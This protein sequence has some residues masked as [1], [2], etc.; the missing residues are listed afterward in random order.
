MKV[1]DIIGIIFI[2][3][4]NS[5]LCFAAGYNIG[6]SQ[7]EKKERQEIL[8]TIDSIHKQD[9]YIIKGGKKDDQYH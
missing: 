7:G 3:I 5:A 4:A 1:L 6:Y 8:N 9:G 2:I